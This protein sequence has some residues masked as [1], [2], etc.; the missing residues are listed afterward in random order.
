MLAGGV[1]T[2]HV[3]NLN[4]DTS[5]TFTLT[6]AN[7]LSLVSPT[8]ST[9]S[10]TQAAPAP[11]VQP[12]VAPTPTP[13]VPVPNLIPTEPVVTTPVVQPAAKAPILGTLTVHKGRT[14]LRLGWRAA[15]AQTGTIVGYR[16]VITHKGKVVQHHTYTAR[17]RTATLTE[18][19]PGTTY[20]LVVYASNSA[21]RT[22]RTTR[23]VRIG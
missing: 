6:A 20:T 9:S 11:V 16:I 12:T 4:P 21:G 22:T 15:K 19:K 14:T 23:T 5:Y 8:V 7:T 18:L 17:T 3:G 13:V 2:A 1:T 10:T